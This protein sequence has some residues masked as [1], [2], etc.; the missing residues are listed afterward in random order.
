MKRS[1]VTIL[2]LL[3]C[4]LAWSQ[5]QTSPAR[6]WDKFPPDVQERGFGLQAS[7]LVQMDDDP[8]LEEVLLFSS[9]NGH[10]P[11]FDIFRLYYVVV[12]YYTKEVKYKSDIV[13]STERTLV[14]EDRNGDGKYEL[15]RKYFQ[16]GD[17]TVDAEGNNLK[18]TWVYDTIECK[19]L[20]N[21][22]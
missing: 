14:L 8:A 21:K 4:T 6:T 9:D 13:R 5:Y 19:Q 15:Y 10:Y 16:N 22:K 3:T 12:D 20:Q 18:V 7:Q 11:Y 1:I 17:F 2:F